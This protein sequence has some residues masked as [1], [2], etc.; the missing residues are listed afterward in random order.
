MM[1]KPELARTTLTES[2]QQTPMDSEEMAGLR[3]IVEG[4]THC[5]GE[6]F[7]ASLVRHLPTA[8]KVSHAF[9]AEFA[10]VNSRA[11]TLASWVPFHRSM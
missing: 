4:T 8:V 11:R 1:S 10:E 3:V 6:A 9:V 7:F 5:V 2:E